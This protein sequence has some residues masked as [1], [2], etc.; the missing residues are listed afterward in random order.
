[1]RSASSLTRMH[2]SRNDGFDDSREGHPG[3]AR[4]RSDDRDQ[5]GFDAEIRVAE[6]GRAEAHQRG[7]QGKPR[8]Q[9]RGGEPQA[10]A[11]PFWNVHLRARKRM[12]QT[13][14]RTPGPTP[15][16]KDSPDAR[17]LEDHGD[18]DVKGPEQAEPE[19]RLVERLGHH[20]L[21]DD[22]PERQRYG[23]NEDDRL[24]RPVGIDD[25]QE[26]TP[27]KSAAAQGCWRA[28]AASLLPGSRARL[29]MLFDL[30]LGRSSGPR[31]AATQLEDE[32]RSWRI[33]PARSS[34]GSFGRPTR[35]EARWRSLA[36]R[37]S[38]SSGSA[39]RAADTAARICP[40]PALAVRARASAPR[41][42]SHRS[43]RAPATGARAPRQAC[44][45]AL[46]APREGPE[47]STRCGLGRLSEPMVCEPR[48]SARLQASMSSSFCSESSTSAPAYR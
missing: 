43:R 12:S 38:S 34:L 35:N 26:A 19:Q 29:A 1:M 9:A 6:D 20:G 33:S 44:A 25:A 17:A 13:P 16:A 14:L 2:R 7:E 8:P 46:F 3:G 4:D 32:Q 39:A 48:W 36:C 24:D 28:S 23:P 5:R 37:V 22:E 11:N 31:R 18:H 27:N 40:W 41:C 45:G 30:A 15:R 42:E 10:L 47:G 21:V